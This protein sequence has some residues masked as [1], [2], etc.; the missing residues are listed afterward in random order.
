MKRA[1]V[2]LIF[3]LLLT[4]TLSAQTAPEVQEKLERLTKDV[5]TLIAANAELQRKLSAVS[6][7]LDRVQEQQAKAANSNALDGMHEELRKLAEKIQEVD[8]K[9]INDNEVVKTQLDT[10]EKLVKSGPRTVTPPKKVDAPV[11]PATPAT[12]RAG[13]EYV[14]QAGDALSVIIDRANAQF[15]EKGLKKKVT[16]QQVTDANPGLNPDKIHT[17]QK[18]FIPQP[19]S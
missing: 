3:F 18:I 16:L 10:I 9:R 2:S 13:L 14:V 12:D 6:A 11:K 19:E 4:I 17:G 8:K 7:E 15:K 5:E 1:F